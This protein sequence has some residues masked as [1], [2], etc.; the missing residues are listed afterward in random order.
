MDVL[1]EATNIQ[2]LKQNYKRL[3]NLFHPDRGGDP[4]Q[5][6]K[7]N[8]LYNSCIQKLKYLTQNAK[9]DLTEIKP[10]HRIY[11]NGTPCEV[12]EVKKDSFRVVAIGRN[13]QAVFNKF[14]GVGKYNKRLKASLDP[15]K[16]KPRL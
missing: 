6:Q 9:E 1:I 3:A 15:N 2:E 11:V 5:M 12:L 14:T 4:V 7:L 13:R 8:S 10:G 16:N